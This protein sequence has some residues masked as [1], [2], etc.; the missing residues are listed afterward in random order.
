MGDDITYGVDVVLGGLRGVK[1]RKRVDGVERHGIHSLEGG[2]GLVVRS[3]KGWVDTY[4][5]T[6]SMNGW[7]NK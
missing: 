2:R 7:R 4:N 1:G 3:K 5:G 6:G